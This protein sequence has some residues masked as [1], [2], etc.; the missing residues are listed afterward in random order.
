M[1][2]N[3]QLLQPWTALAIDHFECTDISIAPAHFFVWLF[4]F[5]P[6][7]APATPMPA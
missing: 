5:C 7:W 6:H 3:G 1:R 4:A 2:R